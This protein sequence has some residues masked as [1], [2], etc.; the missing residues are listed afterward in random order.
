MEIMEREPQLRK[1]FLEALP[2][3]WNC[4]V[5][6]GLYTVAV[7]FMGEWMMGNWKVIIISTTLGQGI[8]HLQ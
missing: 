2:E 3:E 4:D 8:T 5:W 1:P 6:T 7:Q